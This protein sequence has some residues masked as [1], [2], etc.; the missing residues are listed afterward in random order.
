MKNIFKI[1]VFALAT[2]AISCSKEDAKV[3]TNYNAQLTNI[4][5]NVIVKTYEDLRDKSALLKQATLLLETNPTSA[6]LASAKNAWI[7]ARSPWEQSEGF[8][9]GPVDQSAIDPSIDSWPV[10]VTDLN[11]VLGSANALTE[12]YLAN[13]EGTL[14]GFHTIEFL[15]WGVNSNKQ[16]GDFTA[17]EFEYLKSCSANLASDTNRLFNLW[18]SSGGNFISNLNNAGNGSPVYSSQKS[19][20]LEL[21]NKIIGIADEVGNG[22][23]NDPFSQND[24]TLEESRFSAN[25]KTDFTN[26]INSIKNIYL[27]T[28]ST[29]GNGSGISSIVVTKN[30][31]VDAKIKSQIDEAISAIQNISGTFTSAVTSQSATVTFAQNKVRTLQTTLESELKPIID[32]L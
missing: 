27:G 24:F 23:I 6:N 20:L 32:G 1:S 16:I 28:F 29:F 15:L 10:N 30:T 12:T 9:F 18:A 3:E 25:S 7:S 5:N 13:Q 17:R 26:N 4:G 2:L 19:A 31:T 8:L 11:N 22:K 21:T 14:K